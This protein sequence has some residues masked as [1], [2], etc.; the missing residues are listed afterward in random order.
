M[1][2]HDVVHHLV[3]QRDDY[4]ERAERAE[5]EL[6]EFADRCVELQGEVV[7]AERDNRDKDEKIAM[8]EQRLSDLRRDNGE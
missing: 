4:K 1:N 2:E 6:A 5:Q 7:E 8:L 3:Q